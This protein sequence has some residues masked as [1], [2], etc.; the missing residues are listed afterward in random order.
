MTRSLGTLAL[1][2]LTV[3]APLESAKSTVISTANVNDL[4]ISIAG[5]NAGSCHGSDVS[6]NLSGGSGPGFRVGGIESAACTQS[7]SELNLDIQRLSA[8]TVAGATSGPLGVWQQYG[9]WYGNILG[10]ASVGTSLTWDIQFSYSYA[11]ALTGYDGD[12][13]DKYKFS[14]FG[15][16]AG[17]AFLIGVYD[18]C[19][20]S[21]CFDGRVDIFR[22]SFLDEPGF[23]SSMWD[24]TMT[25][26]GPNAIDGA[27]TVAKSFTITADRSYKYFIFGASVSTYAQ[28][29]LVPVSEPSMLTLMV[30]A[31][32]GLVLSNR[33]WRHAIKRRPRA[34]S[35]RPQWCALA[36]A[37]IPIS[38][39]GHAAL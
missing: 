34:R 13:Y 32:L 7:G 20:Q 35:S 2:L 14:E 19:V 12:K 4:S 28:S 24:S 31:T 26:T 10:S 39:P 9:Y 17:N 29:D 21:S 23:F 16:V 18:Q 5:L 30:L 37:S 38:A 6:E 8:T 33:K 11:M 1:A 27:G 15:Q 25:A 36:H 3:L 22:T